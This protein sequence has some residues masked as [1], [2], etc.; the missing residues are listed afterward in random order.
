MGLVDVFVGRTLLV[1]A[2]FFVVSQGGLILSIDI[3]FR[4]GI[5]ALG[6]GVMHKSD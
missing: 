2:E 3:Y 4:E 6:G 1:R 5:D